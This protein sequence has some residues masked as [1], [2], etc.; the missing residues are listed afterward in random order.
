M[1]INTSFS[2]FGRSPMPQKAPE[3]VEAAPVLRE[4]DTA[5]QRGYVISGAS[6]VADSS[7]ASALWSAQVSREAQDDFDASSDAVQVATEN[8]YREFSN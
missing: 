3:A 1:Q 2:G 8:L 4:S 5:R 6:T 7:L